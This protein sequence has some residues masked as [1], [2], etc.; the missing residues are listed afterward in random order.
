MDNFRE[1]VCTVIGE[2]S[3]CWSEIPTGVFDST[4]AE[5]L[6]EKICNSYNRKKEL[7]ALIHGLQETMRPLLK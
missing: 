7:E 1:L 3:M 5:K 2:A 6:V 4:R